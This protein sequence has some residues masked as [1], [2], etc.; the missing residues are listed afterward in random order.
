M[1]LSLG[2]SFG[3][4]L[5]NGF[6]RVTAQVR[7]KILISSSCAVRVFI[8][9][10]LGQQAHLRLSMRNNAWGRTSVRRAPALQVD[11]A[12]RC[13]FMCFRRSPTSAVARIMR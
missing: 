11:N 9:L 1:V 13:A 5:A 12:K 4:G 6:R 7:Q 8:L 2:G 10:I 3:V